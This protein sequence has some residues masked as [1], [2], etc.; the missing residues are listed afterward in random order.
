MREEKERLQLVTNFDELKV[1]SFVQVH[2]WACNKDFRT[3][4]TK[5]ERDDVWTRLGTVEKAD[6]WRGQPE[7][8]CPNPYKPETR[9][10]IC[11]TRV[12]IQFK[13]VWLIE[14]GLENEKPDAAQ[15][16]KPSQVRIPPELVDEFVGRVKRYQRG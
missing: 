15:E 6:F 14:T 10:Q 2:C 12:S 3:I 13:C 4:L 8:W 1:A 16:P 11:V 7:H 5:L 9:N